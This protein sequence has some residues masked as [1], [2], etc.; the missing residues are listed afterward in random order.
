MLEKEDCQPEKSKKAVGNLGIATSF[1]NWIQETIN[2]LVD[3]EKFVIRVV[4][5][6]VDSFEWAPIFAQSE[7]SGENYDD[8]YWEEENLPVETPATS[9]SNPLNNDLVSDNN[10]VGNKNRA[11]YTE[12]E[13][14]D[15]RLP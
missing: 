7:F 15:F 10:S 13:V 4:E 9:S 12:G 8:G 14:D 5:K 2:V 11:L 3:G 6:A 1:S